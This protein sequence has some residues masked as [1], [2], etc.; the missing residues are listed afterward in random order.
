M[1]TKHSRM[2]RLRTQQKKSQRSSRSRVISCIHAAIDYKI[3]LYFIV[4]LRCRVGLNFCYVRVGLRL[5]KHSTSF[6]F[7][8]LKHYF[9]DS[10]YGIK[11]TNI[12][13]FVKIAC[14]RFY[15]IMAWQ[16]TKC[17]VLP[18]GEK[19][20]NAEGLPTT[21]F[22]ISMFNPLASNDCLFIKLD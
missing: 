4:T 21:E 12:F 20:N 9:P 7:S 14:L 17:V 19:T 2:G 5:F 1:I 13:F 11:Y 6:S 18:T 22:G 3:Y 15:E 10:V 16:W 8:V